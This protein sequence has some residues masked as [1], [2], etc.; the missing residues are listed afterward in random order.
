MALHFGQLFGFGMT[1][2]LCLTDTVILLALELSA[3]IVPCIRFHGLVERIVV[4]RRAL[5][6]GNAAVQ[7]GL[8]LFHRALAYAASVEMEPTG[9]TQRTR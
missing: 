2:L 1:L 3:P 9:S 6:V 4:Q 8:F 5:A 7:T